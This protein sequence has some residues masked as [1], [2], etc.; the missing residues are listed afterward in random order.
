MFAT[1]EPMAKE[2]GQGPEGGPRKRKRPGPEPTGRRPTVLTI[3]GSLE[4]KAW[5]D[6]LSKHC[7]IGT[8]SVVDLALAEFAKKQGFDEPPPP[9]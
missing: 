8:S 5:L 2:K 6:R 3:K 4:W 7:R 1:A 9:R